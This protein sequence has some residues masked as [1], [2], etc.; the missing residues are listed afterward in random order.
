M[1]NA[2][3]TVIILAI[4]ISFLFLVSCEKGKDDVTPPTVSLL[5]TPLPATSTSTI[6]FEWK[7]EDDTTPS[8]DLKYYFSISKEEKGKEETVYSATDSSATS[9]IYTVKSDGNYH[10][11][12]S[13]KDLKGNISN[14]VKYDFNVDT[15]P[16]SSPK[17]LSITYDKE[18]IKVEWKSVP[19]KDV[20]HYKIYRAIDNGNFEYIGYTSDTHFEDPPST[21]HIF[22]YK[23]SAVDNVG[24]ESNTSKQ[25]VKDLVDT[26]PPQ[27]LK[28]DV[29][30]FTNKTA[31][32]VSLNITDII[33]K[34]E[35]V[36]VSYKLDNGKIYTIYLKHVY[37]QHLS[38]GKHTVK[39]WLKDSSGNIS[40]PR[41]YQFM[42]DTERPSTVKN[43]SA[44]Y[45]ANE[46]SVMLT[47][48][49]ANDNGSGLKGYNIYGKVVGEK[50][51]QKFNTS[52]VSATYF[53]VSNIGNGEVYQ[54]AVTSMDEAGNEGKK[55]SPSLMFGGNLESIREHNVKNI[56]GNAE[57]SD[58]SFPYRIMNII[59]LNEGQFL[60]VDPGV[61]IIFEKGAKI[62]LRG[63]MLKIGLLEGLDTVEIEGEDGSAVIYAD[64][65]S[66]LWF[67]NVRFSSSGL[68]IN[69]SKCILNNV[70][71]I[72]G[73]I[74][75]ND[76]KSIF[77]ESIYMYAG[78]LS[79]SNCQNVEIKDGTI[80]SVL[81]KGMIIS[82]S[83]VG[84]EDL[85]IEN[86]K[87]GISVK[88]LSK[89]K[90]TDIKVKNVENFA[91]VSTFSSF[92]ITNGIF[93]ISGNGLLV[94]GT[95]KVR[96]KD[97]QLNGGITAID[98]KENSTVTLLNTSISSFSLGLSINDSNLTLNDVDIT[99]SETAIR[100]R[101]S[102]T[103]LK[104][105]K[106]IGNTTAVD[107]DDAST[108]LEEKNKISF[109]S[110]EKDLV[111]SE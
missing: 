48:N 91:R 25:I 77:L 58:T 81:S 92:S 21:G 14:P 46:E 10:F 29:P 73:N 78:S 17:S 63:G 101:N 99:D 50:E 103:S 69:N 19:D 67:K 24:N 86:T 16:P 51:W 26:L 100:L 64:E 11:E 34:D 65:D 27:I 110:N 57:F 23:I 85:K 82:R 87:E 107:T 94:N 84:I 75:M 7:G 8:T 36:S 89:V 6:V 12:L 60:Q 88:D 37:L 3:T 41:E 47:W 30:E 40:P 59:N 66:A 33:D 79:I 109:L 35:N 90:M 111:N 32:D 2:K 4:I 108:L 96:L 95:S 104:D 62:V 61:H 53:K 70:R 31:V 45:N 93:Q 38:E 80:S 20:D 56:S 18:D 102:Y 42:V 15:T 49:K 52:L 28:A 68:V 72:N 39:I 54:F 55:S 106:L 44:V 1:G 9:V 97:I 13:A 71:V 5:L 98:A 74:D 76:N 105:V 83:N 43:L 22:A